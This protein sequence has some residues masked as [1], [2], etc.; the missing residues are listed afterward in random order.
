M[1]TQMLFIPHDDTAAVAWN[2]K[3]SSVKKKNYKNL[4]IPF[5]MEM[6]AIVFPL[7]LTST[8]HHFAKNTFSQNWP[9]ALT[10]ITV[11][12]L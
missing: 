11:F 1:Q 10:I 8:P 6:L 7:N 3:P 2:N 4:T 12:Q 5:R 9:A